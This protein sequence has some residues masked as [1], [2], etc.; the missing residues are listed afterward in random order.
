[1]AVLNDY[2]AFTGGQVELTPVFHFLKG[3]ALQELDQPEEAITS[4]EA[5]LEG[6]KG[7]SKL[8]QSYIA[9]AHRRLAELYEAIG[10][11]DK[12]DEHR[13]IYRTLIP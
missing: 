1:M 13:A 11:A 12:R 6:D 2:T 8:A 4:I 10:R 3:V 7:T 5:F 9:P